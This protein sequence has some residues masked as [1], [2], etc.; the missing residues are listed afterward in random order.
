MI[1]FRSFWN[2]LFLVPGRIVKQ[3]ARMQRNMPS[4]FIK[5]DTYLGWTSLPVKMHPC[6]VVEMRSD[7]SISPTNMDRT[8]IVRF[9]IVWNGMEWYLK[10]QHMVWYSAVRQ[11]LVWYGQDGHTGSR[12]CGR[13][14][15]SIL[16]NCKIIQSRHLHL[17]KQSTKIDDSRFTNGECNWK[18]VQGWNSDERKPTCGSVC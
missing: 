9:G 13:C 3:E 15:F 4:V 14:L 18:Q 6:S 12:T 8:G 1:F 10:W 17:Q 11:G 16:C 5:L 7:L 2:S